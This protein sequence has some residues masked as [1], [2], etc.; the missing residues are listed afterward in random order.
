MAYLSDSGNVARRI[1]LAMLAE[2]EKRDAGFA[3]A[4]EARLNSEANGGHISDADFTDAGD[5]A[6]AVRAFTADLP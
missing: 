3:R 6:E 4:V 5:A 1:V 2:L